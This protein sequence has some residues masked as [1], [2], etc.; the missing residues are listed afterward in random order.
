MFVTAV[1]PEIVW[2]DKPAS[3]AHVDALLSASPPRE[4]GLVVLPEMFATGFSLNVDA[5]DEADP[6]PSEHFLADLAR[7]YRVTI[8]GGVVHRDMAGNGLNQ[9]VAFDAGGELLAR[10]SKLHPFTFGAEGEHFV[11]GDRLCLFENQ[12][13]WVAPL[14][15]YDLR[16]P[17]PFRLVAGA[18][19]EVMLVIANWPAARSDH[20]LT[21]LKAR[22]I[23]NQAYVV[24]VNRAGEDP[25]V[26]YAGDT[27]IFGPRGETIAQADDT[28]CVLHASLDLD[29]LRTGRDK[30]PALRDRR[31]DYAN[32]PITRTPPTIPRRSGRPT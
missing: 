22:A 23:E 2:E 7:R 27:T 4:G 1:Q 13:A 15:C 19:A 28:P 6:A 11:G 21:L 16:F 24:G 32:L 20:W 25:H 17:E 29:A 10:Y 8:V 26:S 18:G 14:I 9:A 5:I 30:F 31:T 3:H 12:N